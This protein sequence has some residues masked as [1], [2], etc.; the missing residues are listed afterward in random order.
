MSIGWGEL[1]SSPPLLS[2]GSQYSLLSSFLLGKV[3]LAQANFLPWPSSPLVPSNLLS[4]SPLLTVPSPFI[5]A[6]L[7]HRLT[8]NASISGQHFCSLPNIHM[9]SNCLVSQAYNTLQ[10]LGGGV[11]IPHG[12]PGIRTEGPREHREPKTKSSPW[13]SSGPSLAEIHSKSLL[14]DSK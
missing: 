5:L 10:A 9:F 8:N 14:Y 6:F 13:G 1:A 12:L 4:H 2:H 3:E 7:N 11:G